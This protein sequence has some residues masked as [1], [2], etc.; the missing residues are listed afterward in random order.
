M[1]PWHRARP[2]FS[3][4][5]EV[6]IAPCPHERAEL[7]REYRNPAG[8]EQQHRVARL[9]PALV[10]QRVPCRERGA[11]QGRRLGV[12]HDGPGRARHRRRSAR[13]LRPACRRLDRPGRSP[14]R[15]P[16]CRR[17]PSLWKKQ[18]AT[19][20]PAAMPATP[21]PAAV[22]SP[23]P[24]E[25]GMRGKRKASLARRTHRAQVAVVDRVRPHANLDLSGSRFRRRPL[26]QFEGIDTALADD[27]P[28]FHGSL[29]PPH[30]FATG[31][32][33]LWPGDCDT[34]EAGL[35]L[36]AASRGR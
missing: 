17:P 36:P 10:D 8:A 22:T 23:A 30:V 14:W 32:Y 4:L 2:S 11:G 34:L 20:S 26:G 25:F 35:R 24:S 9:E 31:R 28:D 21:G 6:T 1:R 3:S 5:F 18:P 15:W 19:R 7:Q 13:R 27:L 12:I 16:R 29:R 33:W